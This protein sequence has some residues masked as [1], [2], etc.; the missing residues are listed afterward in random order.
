MFKA[1][2]CIKTTCVSGKSAEGFLVLFRPIFYIADTSPIFNIREGRFNLKLFI[3]YFVQK[4]HKYISPI[5]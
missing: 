2:L 4:T 5:K 1:E 3:F